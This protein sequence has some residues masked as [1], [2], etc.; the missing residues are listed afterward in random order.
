MNSTEQ[1]LRDHF[2][3]EKGDKQEDF[4]RFLGEPLVR[5]ALAQIPPGAHQD[6]LRL[7]LEAAYDR[8]YGRG[9]GQIAMM[10]VGTMI[11]REAKKS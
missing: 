9:Q 5:M 7:L 11:K 1:E 3:K 4:K 6:G 2:D 10:M 8:G